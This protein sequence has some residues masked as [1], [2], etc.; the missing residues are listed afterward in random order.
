MI[1][2]DE[3][4]ERCRGAQP[5]IPAA[6][7]D[8]DIYR[9]DD[10]MY[11]ASDRVV[12]YRGGQ[13]TC[14]VRGEDL[15]D[16]AITGVDANP[17]NGDVW[18]STN[19]GAY[20]YNQ[21][22]GWRGFTRPVLRSDFVK[23]VGF[24]DDGKVWVF[25][26]GTSD[27]YV[28]LSGA[29]GEVYEQFS[30]WPTADKFAEVT[31]SIYGVNTPTG[32]VWAFEASRPG[33]ETYSSAGVALEDEVEFH[34]TPLSNRGGPLVVG[35]QGQLSRSTARGS[36]AGRRRAVRANYLGRRDFIC[37]ELRFGDYVG[38]NTDATRSDYRAGWMWSAH[39]YGLKLN[40]TLYQ[41]SN[42]L[43]VTVFEM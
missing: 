3:A 15:P 29:Q 21:Q 10:T 8:L 17:L 41:T 22:F 12:R 37:G 40:E 7:V 16:F 23:Q 36:S 38:P 14:W 33:L 28:T 18:V 43:P 9:A 2:F 19:G 39:H 4:P 31:E 6:A 5:V 32:T 30:G 25:S 26:R 20:R 1:R 27:S 34:P 35:P 11:V 42:D 24:S 13:Y